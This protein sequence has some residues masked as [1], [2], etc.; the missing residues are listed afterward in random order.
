MG[1]T[2][3]NLF[4]QLFVRPAGAASW[5]LVTP[6]DVATNG[7]I[8][9]AAGAGAAMTAAVHPSLLLAFS[10]IVSTADG[11]R[12]WSAQPPGPRLASVPDAVAAAPAGGRLMTLGRDGRVG[13]LPAG[14]AGLTSLAALART[15][16]GQACQ[17][18]GLTAVAYSPAG[19]PMVAG[20]CA[21]P[22]VA[23]I[24][25]RSGAGWRA[26]G[27]ALPAALAG[28][29]VEVLRLSRAGRQLTALLQ[30]GAGPDASLVAA[31]SSTGSS[32]TVSAPVRLAGQAVVSSSFGRGAVAV[33]LTGRRGELLAGPS[34]RWQPL[35][36]L[37]AGRAVTLALP[38]G[39]G[40]DALAADGSV[41]TAWQLAAGQPARGGYGSGRWGRTQQTTVPIQYGSSS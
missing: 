41:L 40:V 18:T 32:W 23:G 5:T 9:L 19:A 11:G 31:W 13:L 3:P 28:Q 10:P 7:A 29:R 30:A 6:P 22:G 25:L 26:T 1:T 24:F 8:S 15:A 33:G 17:L 34:A 2:G 20:Q 36:E 16:A 14:P 4:W 21:R 37:P 39:G 12:A 35:P 27:P 38:A